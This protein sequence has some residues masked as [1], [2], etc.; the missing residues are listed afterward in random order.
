MVKI[1]V[2]G[3]MKNMGTNFRPSEIEVRERVPDW[4]FSTYMSLAHKMPF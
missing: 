3:K 1:G 4:P 2:K